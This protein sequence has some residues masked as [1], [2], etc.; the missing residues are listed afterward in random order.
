VDHRPLQATGHAARLLVHRHDPAR[1]DGIP[2]AGPG[3]LVLRIRQL[4]P[5]GGTALRL[6]EQDDVTAALHH[7]GHEGLVQPDRP[8]ARGGVTH[9]GLKHLESGTPGQAH[10]ARH[11]GAGDGDRLALLHAGQVPEARAV[12]VAD[13]ETREQIAHGVQADLA[14]IGG[15]P[16]A[17]ALERRQRSIE[18]H[19]TT[20]ARA[21]WT[22]ISRMPAGNSKGASIEMP[23]GLAE[24][25]E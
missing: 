15:A 12:L 14:E 23:A 4:E 13:R 21:G 18:G 19:W 9:H 22:R 8:D 11:D 24:V 2:V 16:R 25:R 7:A 3:H 5:A 1:V 17:D 20:M 6:A 10:A